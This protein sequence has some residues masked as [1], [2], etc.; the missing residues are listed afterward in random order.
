M[1][2]F[3]KELMKRSPLAACVLEVCDFLFDD[4]LLDEIW[5]QH[6]GRCYEDV[7]RFADLLR[8]M[9]DALVHHGGSAHQLFIELERDEREPVDESNFYRK[10]SNTPVEVGRA[11]LSRCTARLMELLP[12]SSPSSSSSS[13]PL[14]PALPA[15]FDGFALIVGDGKKIKNAAKRLA[16]TRGYAGK[17]IGAK[18][19]VAMDLRS[20]M[21]VAMSDS[22]DGLSNDVPLVPALIEQLRQL[23]TTRPILS[24]WDRQF[25]DLRTLGHLSSRPGDAF[26][27]R[28]KQQNYRFDVESSVRTRDA[29]GRTV[30]DEIGV[31]STGKGKTAAAIKVR[32]VTLVRNGEDEDD[33]V[34]LS[35]LLDR[36]LFSAADLLELYRRRWGIEQLFQQVTE[37]FSLSHLIGSSPRA[38][39]LQFA[40]CLLL[41]NLVQLIKIYVAQDG[42]VLASVV[43]TFYL[44]NDIRRELQAWAYHTDGNWPRHHRNAAQMRVRLEQLLLGSWDPIAY[45][46]ASDRQPRPKRA[47]PKR[48]LGGHSS[49]QRLLEGRAKV[50]NA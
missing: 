50:I 31:L 47:P 14:L 41:Y 15:C 25:D 26:L 20:G 1:D 44:F 22:L 43:S 5:E 2:S 49:V 45:I 9:R 3:E 32:R 27:V 24:I 8:L 34:L 48:L 46:K 10:L 39:L 37:T 18:A 6:R 23:I 35:N 21:A 30:I 33:V 40:Y 19:L 16:P 17:L 28:V 4:A 11:L 29:Q 38:V 36:S 13:S 42:H 12:S 7:L